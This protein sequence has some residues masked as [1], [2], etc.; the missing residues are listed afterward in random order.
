MSKVTVSKDGKIMRLS[1]ERA[2]LE[3]C[4]GAALVAGSDSY[5][6]YLQ[7]AGLPHPS[8]TVWRHN[9]EQETDNADDTQ[10]QGRDADDS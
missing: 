3:I 10:P 1:A 7:R 6:A 9:T 2:H 5:E 4:N 8:L